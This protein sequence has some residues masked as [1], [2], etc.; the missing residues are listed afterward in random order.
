MALDSPSEVDLVRLANIVTGR[1][2]TPGQMLPQG[3]RT[4]KLLDPYLRWLYSHLRFY[5]KPQLDA[6][7]WFQAI[8]TFF[9]NH[10]NSHINTFLDEYRR[11]NPTDP[12]SPD[13]MRSHVLGCLSYW[14]T[15]EVLHKVLDTIDE[16]S[17]TIDNCVADLNSPTEENK[18]GRSEGDIRGG[19]ISLKE[20]VYNGKLIPRG[21]KYTDPLKAINAKALNVHQLVKF[22][23]LKVKWTTDLSRHLE[24]VEEE[25][26]VYIFCMPCIFAVQTGFSSTQAVQGFR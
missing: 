6:I 8:I 4:V 18:T 7:D 9:S 10:P 26:Q 24:I 23:R 20:L 19:N 1:Y 16:T 5:H 17:N 2:L 11:A 3:H 15:I 25:E 12:R 14:M 21:E 22:G 13:L